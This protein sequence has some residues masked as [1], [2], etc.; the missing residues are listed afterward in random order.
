[1]KNYILLSFLDLLPDDERVLMACLGKIPPS[2]NVS[3]SVDVQEDNT[4][5][6][7][8]FTGNWPNGHSD[9]DND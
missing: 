4:G 6:E 5:Q 8:I 3:S 9:P 2:V 1:M 7:I